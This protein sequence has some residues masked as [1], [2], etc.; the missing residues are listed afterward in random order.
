MDAELAKHLIHLAAKEYPL[1]AGM[2]E[3]QF[4][5]FCLGSS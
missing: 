4:G 3:P 1:T 2:V 5:G